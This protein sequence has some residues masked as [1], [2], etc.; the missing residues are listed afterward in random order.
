MLHGILYELHLSH[1]S[2]LSIVSFVI[3]A[4]ILLFYYIL[5]LQKSIHFNQLHIMLYVQYDN[6][7]ALKAVVIYIN[8]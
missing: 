5:L 1:L 8:R 3:C 7:K 4:R 2:L 6:V